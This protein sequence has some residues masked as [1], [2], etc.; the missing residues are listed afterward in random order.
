VMEVP[1]FMKFAML[2]LA[3][4]VIILGVWPSFFLNI[5]NTFKLA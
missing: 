2:I 3:V 5:I 4:L 1:F